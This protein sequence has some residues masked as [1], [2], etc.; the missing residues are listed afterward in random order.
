[1]CWFWL[2]LILSWLGDF[3]EFLGMKRGR[4]E[5]MKGGREDT[6]WCRYEILVLS[7][8]AESDAQCEVRRTLNRNSVPVVCDYCPRG[9]CLSLLKALR[10][11]REGAKKMERCHNMMSLRFYLCFII[12]FNSES[13]SPAGVFFVPFYFFGMKFLQWFLNEVYL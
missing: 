6:A 1:M 4:D 5:K 3:S 11:A 13:D 9:R 2:C 12:L 8:S 7:T 10:I